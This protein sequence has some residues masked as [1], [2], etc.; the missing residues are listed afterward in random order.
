MKVR[1]PN[2]THIYRY[3][4]KDDIEIWNDFLLTVIAQ[5]GI[6]AQTTTSNNKDKNVQ[7]IF[8]AFQSLITRKRW[9]IFQL[10]ISI[11]SFPYSAG[12]NQSQLMIQMFVCLPSQNTYWNDNYFCPFF[13]F[14]SEFRSYM[15]LSWRSKSLVF[16]DIFH[17]EYWKI[18]VK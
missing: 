8:L 15:A 5:V 10:L 3:K 14:W 11:S 2:W 16:N 1:K 4:K 9:F 6:L 17:S 13:F 12:V 18:P 7:I